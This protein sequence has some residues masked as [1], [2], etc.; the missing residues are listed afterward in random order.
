[1]TLGAA[2]AQ[3][4]TTFAA[5]RHDV[6]VEDDMTQAVWQTDNNDQQSMSTL[7]YIACA[8]SQLRRSTRRSLDA[9]S[10]LHTATVHDG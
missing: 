8:V 10:I 1:M 9:S 5:T 4:F 3:S 6:D 7:I 2:F